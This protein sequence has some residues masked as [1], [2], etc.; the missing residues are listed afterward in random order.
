MI[1]GR[2]LLLIGFAVMMAGNAGLVG[3]LVA[4]IGLVPAADDGFGI[5]LVGLAGAVIGYAIMQLAV[6]QVRS[7]PSKAVRTKSF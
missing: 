1:K 7:A 4:Y 6:S 2:N 3:A 5:A